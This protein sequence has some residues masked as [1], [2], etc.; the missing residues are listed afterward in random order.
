MNFGIFYL[1]QT[2]QTEGHTT[3]G[4]KLHAKEPNTLDRVC[5]WMFFDVHYIHV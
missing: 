3:C 5:V 2:L 1:I 4:Q